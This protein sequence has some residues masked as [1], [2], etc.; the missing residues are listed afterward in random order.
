MLTKE[1]KRISGQTYLEKGNLRGN[2]SNAQWK[3]PWPLQWYKGVT[4]LLIQ[5]GKKE[6]RALKTELTGRG[7]S[8]RL[9][10]LV[11]ILR[12]PDQTSSG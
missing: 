12:R 2:N 6:K 11:P 4:D 3:L 10:P 5:R 8:L 7:H 9:E 1:Q